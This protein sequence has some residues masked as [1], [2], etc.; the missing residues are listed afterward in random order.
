MED[1]AV[2]NRI[3]A[4]RKLRGYTQQTFAKK[5]GVSLAVL[6]AVERGVR[7]LDPKLLLKVMVAL[8][9]D[10]QALRKQEAPPH[11]RTGFPHI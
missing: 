9:L 4:L 5:L 1:I 6:G 8:E 7:R 11:P 3:R 2:A 10:E